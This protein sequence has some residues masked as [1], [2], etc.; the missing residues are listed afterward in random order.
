LSW[1]VADLSAGP[2]LA[3][4]LQSSGIAGIVL[5][6]RDRAYIEARQRAAFVEPRAVRIFERWKLESVLPEGSL[7]Q[8]GEI[9]INGVIR[10]M[11]SVEAEGD[12]GRF[13]TQQLLV[14]NLLRKLID[15][16]DAIFVSTPPAS[17]FAMTRLLGQPSPERCW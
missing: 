8:H 17:A 14:I 11:G 12:H 3:T 2:T 16:M 13:C 10:P 5:E 9:R 6:R 15:E 4:F 7:T 1:S